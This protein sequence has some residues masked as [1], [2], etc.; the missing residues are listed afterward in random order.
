MQVAGD[1]PALFL[2]G[3]HMGSP[4][5]HAVAD[6]VVKRGQSLGLV[7]ILDGDVLVRQAQDLEPG[8]QAVVGGGNGRGQE[9]LALHGV[10]AAE[11]FGEILVVALYLGDWAV[12][13]DEHGVGHGFVVA[14]GDDGSA[15][16]QVAHHGR[17]AAHASENP[18]TGRKGVQNIHA[19]AKV[20]DVDVETSFFVPALFF[21][22]PDQEGFVFVHPSGGYFGELFSESHT[23]ER[24]AKCGSEKST[25]EFL[26]TH[27]CSSKLKCTEEN[28]STLIII[29]V[30]AC[31]MI[32]FRTSA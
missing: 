16:A 32:V 20:L 4:Q 15:I 29:H 22:I 14:D 21:R 1:L 5:G 8:A 27:T 24:N 11:H 2:T 23:S 6:A 7:H 26:E 13:T 30:G 12:G 25:D 10:G 3:V 28:P 18:G 9:G 31:T 17:D 19:G